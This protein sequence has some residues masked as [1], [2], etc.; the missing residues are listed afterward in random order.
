MALGIELVGD[1]K[2]C[3]HLYLKYHN[4]TFCGCISNFT[5]LDMVSLL[6]SEL[7]G[8][9]KR[10]ASRIKLYNISYQHS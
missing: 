2:R 4:Y 8:Y 9:H 10:H 6:N 7:I 3:F 1:Y 5:Y